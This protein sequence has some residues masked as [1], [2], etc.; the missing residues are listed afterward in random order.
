MPTFDGGHYFY[1]GLFPLRLE[2]Q[3][4]K[5]GS[6]TV[7]SH[8][9]REALAALPNFSEAPGQ[10]WVSPFARCHVTHFVRLAVIDEPAFN[11][12]VSKDAIFGRG[13]DPLVHQPVD[14]LS[15]PWLMVTVDFDAPDGS[16]P[17][18][19]QWAAGLWELMKPELVAIF[20]HCCEF[21]CREEVKS[22]HRDPFKPVQSGADFA[23]YLARGQIETTMSF[24]DYGVDPPPL[25]DLSIGTLKALAIVPPLLFGFGAAYLRWAPF[26]RPQHWQ[27]WH[28]HWDCGGILLVF[29][30]TLMGL[31][32]GLW[33]VYTM[34]M[35]RGS[36]PFPGV[37]DSDLKAVLKG[38]YLRQRLV[39]F[40][41]D[42]QESD[43]DDLYRAFG[44]LI[45]HVQ[46]DN[47]ESPTQAR[48]VLTT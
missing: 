23:A 42:H 8:L 11:G 41:I 46:P 34:V 14:L 35:R 47:V 27:F 33:L 20:E 12:R 17:S 30:A 15:R 6:F 2:P 32:L 44:E 39:D 13:G 36:R 38:L 22:S 37:A 28:W 48:G 5:D 19:D 24:N 21:S 45:D 31:M 3:Q 25:K 16:D 1:T 4:R 10:R 29:A 9:L 26:H 7:P 18:R 43:P 40:A